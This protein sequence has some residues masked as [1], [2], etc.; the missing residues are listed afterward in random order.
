[1]R[2]QPG[3]PPYNTLAD[4]DLELR[5]IPGSTNKADALLR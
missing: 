5:H 1:M 3:S 4:F 2:M